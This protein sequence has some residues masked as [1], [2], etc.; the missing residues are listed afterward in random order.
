MNKKEATL[1]GYKVLYNRAGKL[2]TERTSTD[3]TLLKQYF[4]AEEYATLQTVVREGT[5]KLDEIHNYIEA[6]LNARRMTD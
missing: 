6:N 1:L 4:T 3:I 2:I 5:N